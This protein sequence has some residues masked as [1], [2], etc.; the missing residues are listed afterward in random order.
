VK[1]FGV[2]RL[3]GLHMAAQGAIADTRAQ[4]GWIIIHPCGEA[5]LRACLERLVR[6]RAQHRKPERPP[7]PPIADDVMLQIASF[8]GEARS[9]DVLRAGCRVSPPTLCLRLRQLLL[10]AP[11]LVPRSMAACQRTS[12]PSETLRA[13]SVTLQSWSKLLGRHTG[14]WGRLVVRDFGV[15]PAQL[16]PPQPTARALYLLLAQTRAELYRAASLR[17]Q[18]DNMA[19]AGI[20]PAAFASILSATASQ[21]GRGAASALAFLQGMQNHHGYGHGFGGSNV[22]FGHHAGGRAWGFSGAARA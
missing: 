12:T 19:R 7:L 21:G 15:N 6:G 10:L 8:V 11:A 9:L 14:I 4:R 16:R 1:A 3:S 2:F 5:R 18:V 13:A 20:P 17:R 22:G